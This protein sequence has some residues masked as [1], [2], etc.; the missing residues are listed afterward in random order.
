MMHYESKPE[1]WNCCWL[2]TGLEILEETLLCRL[3]VSEPVSSYTQKRSVFLYVNTYV[4]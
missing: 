4:P 2:E 1:I 3:L